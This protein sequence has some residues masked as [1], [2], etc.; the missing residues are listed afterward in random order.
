MKNKIK[1]GAIKFN[2]EAFMIFS[3][4][5]VPVKNLSTNKIGNLITAATR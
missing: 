5:N 2:R 4:I 3:L 1:K